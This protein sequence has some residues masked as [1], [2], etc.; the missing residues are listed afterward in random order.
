MIQAPRECIRKPIESDP[1]E[2]RLEI[3]L[4]SWIGPLKEFFANPSSTLDKSTTENQVTY[5]ASS[6]SGLAEMANPA[7]EGRVPCSSA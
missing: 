7:V 4:L 1:I 5:Q 3:K 2:D 6:E